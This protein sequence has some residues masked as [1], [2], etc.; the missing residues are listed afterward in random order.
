MS[1]VQLLNLLNC[2]LI[3]PFFFSLFFFDSYRKQIEID[4]KNCV[5]DIL[6]TAG[7]FSKTF[8]FS[9]PPRSLFLPFLFSVPLVFLFSLRFLFLLFFSFFSP[10]PFLF[11]SK[12]AEEFHCMLDQWIRECDY[13]LLCFSITSLASFEGERYQ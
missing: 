7:L 10:F 5:L 1:L 11:D 12:G 2:I 3:F 8:S 13:F 9:F 6:D 4:G